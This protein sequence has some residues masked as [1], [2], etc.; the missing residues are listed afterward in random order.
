MI[1]KK[2]PV[3]IAIFQLPVTNLQLVK[4]GVLIRQLT[5]MFGRFDVVYQSAKNFTF[6]KLRK[7]RQPKNLG[8][9]PRG[10]RSIGFYGSAPK[11]AQ[12]HGVR[13][14][15]LFFSEKTKKFPIFIRHFLNDQ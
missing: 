6:P 2:N 13:Q 7:S 8:K 1:T 12:L 11:E 3:L 4:R 15:A 5:P 9:T 14:N 10:P